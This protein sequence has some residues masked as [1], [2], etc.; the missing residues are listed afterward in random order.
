MGSASVS[1][2]ISS[3]G[4]S[5]TITWPCG[6][7][8][9]TATVTI[10]GNAGYSEQAYWR[11]RGQGSD[12][13]IYYPLS[14]ENTN[15]QSATFT[16]TY[17]KS[18][19][20][21][22]VWG[23][24]SNGAIFTVTGH[25]YNASNTVQPTCTEQGYT[26]YR[27]SEC[28]DSYRDNY[29]N[30]LGHTSTTNALVVE[31]TCTEQGYTE[32]LCTRCNT[33]LSKDTYTTALGHD[34]ASSIVISPTCIESGYTEHTC[35]RCRDVKKDTYVNPLGHL[36]DEGIITLEPTHTTEGVMKYTCLRDDCGET[37]TVAIAKKTGSVRIGNGTTYDTY[38]IYIYNGSTWDIY[39]PYIF[40]G[41]SWDA[42][43]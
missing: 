8:T 10:T 35:S 16:V 36:W 17:G 38:S 22:A 21:Q 4:V 13:T 25:E 20:F 40:N 24:V 27:C 5:A 23:S 19:A 7:G 2:T 33:V 41:T 3:R 18:Y 15:E 43:S 31:P 14:G 12:S 29:K 37:Y 32:H 6:E 28:G 11:I 30:A 34:Y 42:Y 39:A 9:T 1:Q 26:T